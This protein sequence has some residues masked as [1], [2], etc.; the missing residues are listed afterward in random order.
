MS[1]IYDGSGYTEPRLGLGLISVRSSCAR[2]DAIGHAY[3]SQKVD[4]QYCFVVVKKLAIEGPKINN[5]CN[6]NWPPFYMDCSNADT[7]VLGTRC[8]AHCW[9]IPSLAPLLSS[10]DRNNNN[11]GTKYYISPGWLTA[12]LRRQPRHDPTITITLT[13]HCAI[14]EWQIIIFF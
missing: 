8:W 11:T 9:D 6:M 13:A 2:C 1:R 7:P 4:H 14:C 10:A 5:L 3:C 12:A